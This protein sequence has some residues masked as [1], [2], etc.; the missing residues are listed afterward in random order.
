MGTLALPFEYPC[1]R[2]GFL[3]PHVIPLVPERCLPPPCVE[4]CVTPLLC[5]VQQQCCARTLDHHSKDPLPARCAALCTSPCSALFAYKPMHSMIHQADDCHC[6]M[7]FARKDTC[8]PLSPPLFTQGLFPV[9]V[10]G[11]VNT[12]VLTLVGRTGV[13]TQFCFL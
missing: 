9:A 7:P 13:A 6:G 5:L 3:V 10:C 12:S 8:L 1:S 4:H 11:T 2:N